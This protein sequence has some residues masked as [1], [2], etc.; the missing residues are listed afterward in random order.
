VSL[1]VAQRL[2]RHSNPTLTSQVYTQLEQADLAA[3][4]NALPPPPGEARRSA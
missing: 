1:V 2:A 4:V 3:G